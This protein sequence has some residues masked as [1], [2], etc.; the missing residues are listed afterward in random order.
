MRKLF[1]AVCAAVLVGPVVGVLAPAAHEVS[2]LAAAELAARAVAQNSS[3]APVLVKE[4][5]A[6]A[7]RSAS[8]VSGSPSPVLVKEFPAHA[9]AA[10]GP[11]PV[12]AGPSPAGS[13][14]PPTLGGPFQ[15][16]W[17]TNFPVAAPLD[18]KSVV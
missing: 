6:H 16:V 5:P 17:S 3:P 7:P 13:P 2:G 4:F 9:P 12:S 15:L 11:S 1:L 18:R 10:S 8:L 14:R